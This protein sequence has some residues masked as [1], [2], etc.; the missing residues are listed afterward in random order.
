VTSPPVD[1]L[2][3][4]DPAARP[5]AAVADTSEFR[6]RASLALLDF[7][8]RLGIAAE[9]ILAVR[10]RKSKRV[11]RVSIGGTHVPYPPELLTRAWLSVTPARFA[12]VPLGG[13]GQETDFPDEWLT[14]TPDEPFPPQLLTAFLERAILAIV[15]QR[16]S[17]FLGRPLADEYAEVAQVDPTDVELLRV[18]LD[19]GISLADHGRV[20]EA[21]ADALTAPTREEAVEIA[22]A[23]LVRNRIEVHVAPAHL[24]EL[25]PLLDVGEEPDVEVIAAALQAKIARSITSYFAEDRGLEIPAIEVRSAPKLRRREIQVIVAG[26]AAVPVRGLQPDEFLVR[27]TPE[28]L[29]K[30]G[31]S[32]RPAWNPAWDQPAV[33]VVAE[34][35]AKAAENEFAAWDP[36]QFVELVVTGEIARSAELLLTSDDIEYRLGRLAHRRA[37]LA[38]LVGR[39]HEVAP[40]LTP[41]LRTLVRED[42]SIRN[43]DVLLSEMVLR[44]DDGHDVE[45]A[46]RALAPSIA[47]RHMLGRTLVVYLLGPELVAAARKMRGPVGGA[48][49]EAIRSAVWREL[50]YLPPDVRRPVILTD[51]DTRASIRRILEVELPNVAVLSFAEVDP[52]A[53][54][55][56]V[57]RISL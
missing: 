4:L 9:P 16:P 6:R 11:L 55:Q 15:A 43:L 35:A 1:A 47:Q 23:R 18:L 2:L 22:R 17:L 26:R 32:A 53:N 46:R 3:Q 27:A 50:S 51:A 42:V 36:L 5:L 45:A 57:A 39:S 14:Q 31:V 49:A 34:D 21:L 13:R 20:R 41:R 7:A 8:E 30:L 37:R 28:Q 19:A 33:I 52:D 24:S 38:R 44:G 29:T 54:V 56:P 10:F 48:T 40:R 25:G 12:S